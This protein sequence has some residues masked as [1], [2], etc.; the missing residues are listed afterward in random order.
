MH[1]LRGSIAPVLV[2][3]SFLGLVPSSASAA[4]DLA[5][6]HYIAPNW[7]F[8]QCRSQIQSALQAENLNVVE[9]GANTGDFRGYSQVR[10][11]SD[12]SLDV[13][14]INCWSTNGGMRITFGCASQ[15]P[16]NRAVDLCNRLIARVFGNGPLSPVSGNVVNITGPGGW[17]GVWTRRGTSDVWDA[18]WKNSGSG[19]NVSTT[20][21]GGFNGSTGY[22]KRTQSGDGFLCEYRLRL[23]AD[24]RSIS[25][26]QSCPGTSDYSVSGTLQ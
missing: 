1:R 10:R 20:M 22:F 16:N 19:Q 13:A 2:A 26:T 11:D 4:V 9:E 5:S 12:G 25:G 17:S 21:Q 15:T 24:G 6:A 14:V 7:S 18:P 23:G 3:L 8:Q